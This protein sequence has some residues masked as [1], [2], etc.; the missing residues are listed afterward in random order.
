MTKSTSKNASTIPATHA[1]T[2]GDSLLAAAGLA[3]PQRP[4]GSMLDLNAFRLTQDFGATAGV[5][6][7]TTTIPVRKPGNQSY[8]RVRAGEEWRFHTQMLQLKDDGECYIIPSTMCADLAQ[9]VKPK[10]LYTAISRDGSL[11]L[12]P[13]NLPG[14]DG[15]L[16]AWSQSAHQAARLAENNWIRMVANRSLGAYDVMQATGSLNEPE[17]PDLTFEQIIDLA[18]RD[19]VIDSVEHPILRRLRGEI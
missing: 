9:E 15:R 6:K 11:F 1:L 17:W 10:M 8:V 19:R 16:D 3:A 5:K 12:W 2:T 4:V 14:E 7:I 13:V 18:F